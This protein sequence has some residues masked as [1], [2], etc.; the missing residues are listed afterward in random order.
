MPNIEIRDARPDDAA[1]LLHLVKELAIY[2]RQPDA[3]TATEA[4]FRRD[5]FGPE[6]RFEARLASLDGRPA[7]FALFF[8]NYSTWEGRAGLYLEDIFV[9]EWARRHGVGR[10]LIADLAA[11]TIARGW[12]RLDLSVLD[13][14]PARGFY[15]RLGFEHR[16][17]WLGYRITGTALRRLAEG[18]K[19]RRQE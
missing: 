8:P 17:E 3:V 19:Q 14:N 10:R 1:T 12:A 13:W 7:G 11:I 18:A 2:E 15:H 16:Q 4:D 5:G 6:R 9:A